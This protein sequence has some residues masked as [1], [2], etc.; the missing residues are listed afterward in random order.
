[1][2]TEGV[3]TQLCLMQA[4]YEW[5]PHFSH[6]IRRISINYLPSTARFPIHVGL[7]NKIKH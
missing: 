1:M 3:S 7:S 4:E 2:V 6:F 5:I